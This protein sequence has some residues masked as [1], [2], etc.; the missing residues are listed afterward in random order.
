MDGLLESLVKGIIKETLRY[1]SDIK[2]MAGVDTLTQA[3]ASSESDQ[4]EMSSGWETS[5]M[6]TATSTTTKGGRR[7]VLLE[8]DKQPR[9]RVRVVDVGKRSS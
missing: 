8:K 5:R 9:I 3:S 7:R 2:P 6:R 1:R 4:P